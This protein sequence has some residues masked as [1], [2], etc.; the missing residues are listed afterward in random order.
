MET[1]VTATQTG[2]FTSVD[3]SEDCPPTIAVET[4]IYGQAAAGSNDLSIR[5]PFSPAIVY[6]VNSGAAKVWESFGTM[7]LQPLD[8]IPYTFGVSHKESNTAT[9]GITYFKTN[10][11]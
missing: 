5:L 2:A 11:R 4:E 3:L 10:V 8:T 6:F 1:F 7:E 9:Y